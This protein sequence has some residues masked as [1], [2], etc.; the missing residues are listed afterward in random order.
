MA[1]GSHFCFQCILLI[2]AVETLFLEGVQRKIADL[3]KKI[4]EAQ[5]TK[6]ALRLQAEVRDS[7]SGATTADG[8]NDG[9]EAS[10]KGEFREPIQAS[11]FF[12]AQIRFDIED[13]LGKLWR[14]G[15]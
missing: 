7:D 9:M 2:Q 6:R 15:V 11:K 4:T 5:V 10:S 12:G 1:T 13:L 3:K 14:Q 8:Q